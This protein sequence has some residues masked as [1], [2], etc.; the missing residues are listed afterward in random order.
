MRPNRKTLFELFLTFMKVGVFTFGGGYAMI[1]LI[2]KETVEKHNWVSDDDILE[3]VA[4]AE[5][6]PGSIGINIATFV[7]HRVAG[8]WGALCATLGMILP[9]FLI[10]TLVAYIL[11]GFQN[12]PAVQ[13]AFFG[14]RAGVLALIFK[15]LWNVYRKC[16]K[17]LLFYVI[18]AG[19]F[20]AAAV[21]KINLLC[22]IA[23]CALIGLAASLAAERR[24]GK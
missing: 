6:M 14:I 5:S 18:A 19:S 2:Q 24:A 10:I 7:S 8:F 16:P 17:N 11:D 22:V 13:Y 4:I 23:S 15:A 21:I 20:L 12:V 3:I 1:P 9:S